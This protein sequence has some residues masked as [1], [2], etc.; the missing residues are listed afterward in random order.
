MLSDRRARFGNVADE[1]SSMV[2]ICVPSFRETASLPEADSELSTD[3]KLVAG[4]DDWPSISR[5]QYN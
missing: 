1:T 2:T 3:A 4:V 5:L